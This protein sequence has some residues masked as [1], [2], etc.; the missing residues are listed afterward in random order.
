M[1][2]AGFTMIE[3]IFVIVIL[4]ILAAVA[5]PKLAATRTDA[6]V[7]KLSSN[8]ATV[9]SDLGA[10]YT[11]T[12]TLTGKWEDLT[13]VSLTTDAAGT[14]TAT[15]TDFATGVGVYLGVGATAIKTCYSI[16]ATTEG[17]ISITY[18]AA[19]T[20]PACVAAQVGALKN[21][22]SAAAG[23]AKD[24]DFAGAGVSY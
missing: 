3:L 10:K 21:N 4:G 20:D 18:L 13:N 5:I 15:G 1:K 24:H 12:G 14:T 7:S 8:L 16:S 17:V 6:E 22:I 19:A 2:R 9:L 11:A 23:T